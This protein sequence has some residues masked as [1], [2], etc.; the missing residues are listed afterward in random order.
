MKV[1]KKKFIVLFFAIVLPIFAFSGCG[2]VSSY[3]V[4]AFPS[5]AV[6]GFTSGNGTY[7]EGETV[8]L[9]ATAKQGSCFIAWVYQNS[10]LVENG[11]NFKISNQTDS[12]QKITKSILTF[13][14]NSANQGRYTAVF[15]EEKI[16]YAKFT[17]WRITTDPTKTPD[18]VENAI[19][20]VLMTATLNFSQ[21][22]SSTNLTSIYS[23]E[24]KEI[25]ENLLYKPENITE[26]LKLEDSAKRHIYASA[27]FNYNNK[28]MTIPFRAD[29]EF[30]QSTEEIETS[31]Y[32]YQITYKDGIYEIVFKFK[33]G[34]DKQFYL[35]LD[36]ANLNVL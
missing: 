36:W 18:Q 13:K 8:T 17:S 29:I 10:K 25:K 6:Y 23:V 2:S 11:N 19:D 20:P 31:N 35:V 1:F 28:I 4:T 14:I 21:G 27:Q 22:I 3:P 26:V 30:F 5:S 7:A 15:D 12:A 24:N 16:M 32:S 33:V 34:T 9:T